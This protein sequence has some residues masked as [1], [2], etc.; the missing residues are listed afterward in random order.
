[1]KTSDFRKQLTSSQL[2]ENMNK[3]FGVNVNL[4]KYSREQL[5]DMRNKLR[6]RVFHQEGRA[7]INDL[8]T[9]ET[10]QKDKAMLDLL[11]TRIKEML[12]EDI[13][14]LRDK[15]DQLSEAKNRDRT[16]DNKANFDD[17]QV[18]RMTAGG[19]PKNK[20]IAKATSDNFKEDAPKTTKTASG[21]TVTRAGNTTTHTAGPKGYGN[22]WDGETQ[23]QAPAKPSRAA[24]SSA[25]KKAE[26]S[27]DIK[28]PP[29]KGNVTKHSSNHGADKDDGTGDEVKES[30][31]C[32]DGHTKMTKGCKECAGMYE[33]K[34]KK[35]DTNNNNIPDYAEDGKGPN[36][37]KKKGAAPKKGVNPFAKKKVK[38]SFT[39]FK[40]NVR[41][42]NESLDFLLQEDEEGKAKAIT[43]A[44]D[45]VNN[46]TSWM[47]RVG[48][49]QTKTMIELADAIKADFGA[50]EAEA[51]KS[52][53]GPALSSTLE[54]LTQQREAISNAVATLAGEATAEV[55]MGM[56]PGMPA[57]TGMEMS[58]PDEMNP[59]PVGD[60][61]G[62]AD[63]AAG[64]GTTGREMRESTFSQRLQESHS[65]M[66]ALSK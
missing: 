6:T 35:P 8:L 24:K 53:V 2:K 31:E 37:T 5:E 28:L 32:S 23:D 41:F 7:S 61:F 3:M 39:Q 66:S 44:G 57:D 12:G 15:M 4:T 47:Q 65:I 40:H 38:E 63:A 62:A 48:Q 13:K 14:K 20:A 22:K 46:F 27:K 11:N 17:V 9:N 19:V 58:P 54:M 29:W 64:V 50:Q 18:A 52:A 60:E 36:D 10:Y 49:Y 59:E 25:E 56:D 43:S 33:T 16:G 34:G 26:K 21:G 42:V 55:G 45:M 30:K 1:M 51:F